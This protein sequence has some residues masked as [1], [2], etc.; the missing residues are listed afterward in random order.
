MRRGRSWTEAPRAGLTRV[1]RRSCC[2]LPK[3][4]ALGP[5]VVTIQAALC[6]LVTTAARAGEVWQVC[7]ARGAAPL[8]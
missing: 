5:H 4:S 3:A 6:D 1:E 2:T 8:R 7:R